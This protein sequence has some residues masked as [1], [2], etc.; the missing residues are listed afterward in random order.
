MD[1]NTYNEDKIKK[2][3][4]RNHILFPFRLLDLVSRYRGLVTRWKHD[5]NITTL[6]IDGAGSW[7]IIE[8]ESSI[9]IKLKFSSFPEVDI[10]LGKG[11]WNRTKWMIDN[12]IH[13]A[14]WPDIV[15]TPFTSGLYYIDKF[16]E[17][18]SVGYSP[19]RTI[20]NDDWD[21]SN[22]FHLFGTN[23]KADKVFIE[24]RINHRPSTYSYWMSS[25]GI[26]L[27]APDNKTGKIV[28]NLWAAPRKRKNIVPEFQA[29][30]LDYDWVM[31]T[32][33]SFYPFYSLSEA[34]KRGNFVKKAP[35]EI[36]GIQL[37]A[38][39][40]ERF[41]KMGYTHVDGL[42]TTTKNY[43]GEEEDIFLIKKLYENDESLQF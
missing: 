6:E 17:S 22:P 33:Y 40:I 16:K 31:N 8:K 39:V 11:C 15:I 23:L 26:G 18:I 7:E 1:K 27:E 35:L 10:P 12:Y 5:G 14:G 3:H 19:F 21:L 30:W 24:R 13:R 4:F 42:L 43:K 28:F 38:D 34:R 29:W 41:E 37:G 2:E 20:S 9:V 36:A 25:S 32:F